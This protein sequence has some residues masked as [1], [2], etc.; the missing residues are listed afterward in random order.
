MTAGDPPP[1]IPPPG[2]PQ[3]PEREP[4]GP[5]PVIV[6]SVP[7][8]AVPWSDD[9]LVQLRGDRRLMLTG[10]LDQ[11]TADRLC[12]EL[13]LA[14][15]RSTDGI[16]LIINS[17]GGPSEVLPALVDVIALLR[18]PLRTRC[19]GSAT[20][21][22]AI[23]LASGTAGRAATPRSTIGLR[24]RDR[25]TINGRVDD[26]RRDADRIARLWQQIADH[27]ADVS[28]LPPDQ[29]AAALRDGELLSAT[30]ARAAGLIDVIEGG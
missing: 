26:I 5:R 15:G 21:T 24:L 14:D 29:A 9:P 8:H 20:G 18:A 1:E 22:A 30:D 13:M 3:R 28:A 11:E 2:W 6:P 27:V 19:I 10:T 25:H 4:E 7:A 16:E 23:V 12:A 17:P